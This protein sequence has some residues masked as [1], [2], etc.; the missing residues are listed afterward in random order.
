MADELIRLERRRIQLQVVQKLL[1]RCRLWTFLLGIFPLTAVLMQV[2]NP[3]SMPMPLFWG[4]L[5]F[6]VPAVVCFVRMLQYEDRVRVVRQYVLDEEANV[7]L[8]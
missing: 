1:L 7:R 5:V 4:C 8:I 6:I 2:L 3:G